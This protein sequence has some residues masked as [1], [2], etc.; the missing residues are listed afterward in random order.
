MP[1]AAAMATRAKMCDF[2]IS[3]ADFAL[4]QRYSVKQPEVLKSCDFRKGED[5]YAVII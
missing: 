1:I 3:S 4:R 5:H 2:F